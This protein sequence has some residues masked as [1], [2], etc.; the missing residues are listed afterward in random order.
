MTR[1]EKL[2]I[3]LVLTIVVMKFGYLARDMFLAR[4]YGAGGP[5]GYEAL[6]WESRSVVWSGLINLA[7]AI[8]VFVEA[9]SA[10]LRGLIWSLLGL[11]FGVLGVL[12]FYA[13]QIY[14][15]S[16]AQKHNKSL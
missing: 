11:S 2:I 4:Y 15:S 10:Q 13:I 12:L 1:H 5:P 9:R 8:W 16:I 14:R 7:A 3:F 6:V